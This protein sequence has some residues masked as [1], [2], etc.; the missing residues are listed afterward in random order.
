M[1]ELEVIQL[2]QQIKGWLVLI[3]FVLS[4]GVGF[5]V[6]FKIGER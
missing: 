5:F 3:F 1:T 2:L 4:I 6:G